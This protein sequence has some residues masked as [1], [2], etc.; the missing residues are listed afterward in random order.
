MSE[1]VLGQSNDA[2]RRL[3]LQDTL[4]EEPSEWLLKELAL[5]PVCRVVELGCGPGGFSRRILRHMQTG[6]VVVGVDNSDGLLQQ[7]QANLSRVGPGRFE[8]VRADVSTLGPWLG[9]ADAV[10]GRAMLHHVPMAEQ[11]L[12]RLRAGLRSGTPVGF[13]EP[14]FRSPQA[15]IAYLVARGRTEL[16]PLLVWGTAINQLYN[17]NRISPC[18]G[19]TLARTLELCGYRRVRSEWMECHSNEA[20]LENMRWFYAEVRDRLHEKGILPADEV[21]HQRQLLEALPTTDLPA[22]WGMFAVAAES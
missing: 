22:A 15:R 16:E 7:A 5:P 2:A 9:G 17:A 21:D 4:F 13:I 6:G 14:D 1:Y 12:G 8:A 20:M 3:A 11:V 19:A 10:V 18:V